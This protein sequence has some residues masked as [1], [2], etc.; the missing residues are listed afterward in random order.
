MVDRNEID[1]LNLEI[2]YDHWW[3]IISAYT[4]LGYLPFVKYN[5]LQND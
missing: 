5:T 3:G 2:V 1:L 4:V